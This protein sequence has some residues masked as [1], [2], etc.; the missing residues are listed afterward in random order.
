MAKKKTSSKSKSKAKKSKPKVQKPLAADVLKMVDLLP[1]AVQVVDKDGL[2]VFANKSVESVLG[3]KP[4]K[5]KGEPPTVPLD[6]SAPEYEVFQT[7]L[8]WR[9]APATL[10][11]L[12]PAPAAAEAAGSQSPKA[13]PRPELLEELTILREALAEAEGQRAELLKEL[14]ELKEAAA[15]AAKPVEEPAIEE[16]LMG[17]LL[18]RDDGELVVLRQSLA[19]ARERQLALKAEL[20]NLRSPPE[21]AD[22]AGEILQAALQASLGGSVLPVAYQP[23][24]DLA[25]GRMLGLEA[26]PQLV[27]PDKGVLDWALLVEESR[28]HDLLLQLAGRLLVEVC[29]SASAWLAAGFEFTTTMNLS[30]WQMSQDQVVSVLGEAMRIGKIPANKIMIELRQPLVDAAL[31]AS[32]GELSQAGVGFA[33][34]GFGRGPT[35]FE[36]IAQS[37]LL[38]LDPRLIAG[39]PS[40]PHRVREVKAALGLAA[41]MGKTVCAVGVENEEQVRWLARNKCHLAQGPHLSPPLPA[42]QVEEPARWG[43]LYG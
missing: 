2:V 15:S 42:E 21:P 3:L 31:S 19:E 34:D 5:V 25:H 40:D 29:R 7:E 43:R 35:S 11:L 41:S 14:E 20:E 32:L 39:L 22:R 24:F 6:A 18:G 10:Q 16:P 28:T 38:K 23:I 27:L 37:K 17:R 30:A 13:E 26:I 4:S 36:T 12:R 1:E 8:K 33:L 9:R